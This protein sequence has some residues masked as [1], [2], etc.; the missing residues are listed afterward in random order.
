MQKIALALVVGFAGPA[1]GQSFLT[2]NDFLEMCETDTVGAL[3][4]AMGTFDLATVLQPFL[5][6][7]AVLACPPQSI[8]AGQ[9]QDVSCQ[10]V[11]DNPAVRHYPASSLVWGAIRAAWPCATP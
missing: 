9:V 11:R 8:T 4:Y 3:R 6:E 10:Y 5:I 2:G 7:E 1:V